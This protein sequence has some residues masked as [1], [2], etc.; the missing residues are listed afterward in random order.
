MKE[1]ASSCL[2][3][4]TSPFVKKSGLHPITIGNWTHS[5]TAKNQPNKKNT[6]QKNPKP[7][8]KQKNPTLELLDVRLAKSLRTN[9]KDQI[10]NEKKESKD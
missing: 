6:K 5:P 3:I 7:K 10:K 8:H 9:Q 2:Y 1:E 4:L